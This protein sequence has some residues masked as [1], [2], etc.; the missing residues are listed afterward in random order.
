MSFSKTIAGLPT[1]SMVLGVNFV[2]IGVE[3]QEE[4]DY[5]MPFRTMCYDMSMYQKQMTQI[6]RKN[7][8]K[9]KGLEPGEY[10]YRFKKDDK[11]NPVITFVLY[12]GESYWD[13][14]HGLR[15][16]MD[17]TNFPQELRAMVSDYRINVIPIRQFQNTGV[18][19]TD[20]YD[21]VTKYTNSK[22]LVRA[23]EYSTEGGK[24]DVCKAIKDLMSDSRE[25]GREEGALFTFIGLVKDNILSI[26]EAAK[27]MGMTVEEFQKELE[28]E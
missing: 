14:P 19:K 26:E 27:R 11:L 2:I 23:K 10:M 20:A 9:T 22:E 18:F 4:N 21:V 13:G 1:S 5:E 6:Q 8:T 12:A 17:F 24:N 25:E 15:D 16:M 3:N 7:R 28:R